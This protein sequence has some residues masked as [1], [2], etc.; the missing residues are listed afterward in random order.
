MQ[1]EPVEERLFVDE[2]TYGDEDTQQ[3]RRRSLERHSSTDVCDIPIVTILDNQLAQSE[4]E[5]AKPIVSYVQSFLRST[6]ATVASTP[7]WLSGQNNRKDQRRLNLENLMKITEPSEAV[8]VLNR[9]VELK[10]GMYTQAALDLIT[11]LCEQDKSKSTSASLGAEGACSVV[12]TLL[13][14]S[15]SSASLTE[16]ALRAICSLITPVSPNQV[17]N[18]GLLPS[19]SGICTSS[20]QDGIASNRKRFS[21]AGSVYQI[22]KAAGN[23][24]ADEMVLEWGLRVIFYLSLEAGANLAIPA[25]RV[26]F[27]AF[28]LA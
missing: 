7:S 28:Y 11:H 3:G 13:G 19:T 9:A 18:A 4:M 14:S 17:P 10:N 12:E 6:T 21:S 5:S 16:A 2:S 23:Y 15:L 25:C 8:E 1:E 27:C 26:Q 22:I 20:A 24:I